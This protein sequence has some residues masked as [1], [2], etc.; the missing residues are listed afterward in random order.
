MGPPINRHHIEISEPRFAFDGD[1]PDAAEPG[2]STA[3]G[4]GVAISDEEV[5]SGESFRAVP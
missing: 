5:G 2:C 4:D 1:G 3:G